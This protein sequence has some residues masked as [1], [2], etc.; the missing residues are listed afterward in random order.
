MSKKQFENFKDKELEEVFNIHSRN[1]QVE[2]KMGD[3]LVNIKKSNKSYVVTVFKFDT[4]S[5]RFE[6]VFCY[7]VDA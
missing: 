7:S 6:P 3:F 1:N 4:E 2:I 5:D